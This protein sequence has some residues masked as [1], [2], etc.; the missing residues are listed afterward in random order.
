MLEREQRELDRDR[1]MANGISAIPT[2]HVHAREPSSSDPAYMF[3]TDNIQ[4]GLMANADLLASPIHLGLSPDMA[5]LS[6]ATAGPGA[7]GGRGL[8]VGGLSKSMLLTD[9]E[10]EMLQRELAKRGSALVM[11]DQLDD[12]EKS[13]L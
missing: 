8:G 4:G 9:E 5:T 1:N 3:S 6:P 11:S 10:R 12:L 7:D 13:E 2:I